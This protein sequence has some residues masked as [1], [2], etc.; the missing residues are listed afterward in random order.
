MPGKI[1]SINMRSPLYADRVVNYVPRHPT[2]G[3]P[4]LFQRANVYRDE[5]HAVKLIHS[6]YA[7]EQLGLSPEFPIAKR[8]FFQIAHMGM[9]SI[10]RAM[11]R[12]EGNHVL[13]EV[14][15]GWSNG[16]DGEETWSLRT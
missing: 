1:S 2:D 13:E 16:R 15:L 10:E 4:E 7:L 8:D 6:L 11:D 9:G 14:G 5:G 12:E 3:W